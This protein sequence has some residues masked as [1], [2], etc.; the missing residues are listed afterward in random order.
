[1]TK[2]E[3]TNIVHKL[4]SFGEDREELEFWVSIYD[5]LDEDKRVE[6]E[7]IVQ[8]ELQKLSSLQ[9]K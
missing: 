4:I 3:F 2:P 6:L 5:D 9:G 8:D 1:M 7:K